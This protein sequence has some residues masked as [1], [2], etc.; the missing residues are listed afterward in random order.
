VQ[1]FHRRLCIGTTTTQMGFFVTVL[2]AKMVK[3]LIKD[4]EIHEIL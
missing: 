1:E 4:C 2:R 3:S